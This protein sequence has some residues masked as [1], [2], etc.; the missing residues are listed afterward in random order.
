M[1]SGFGEAGLAEIA[2]APYWLRAGHRPPPPDRAN[3]E[4]MQPI[5]TSTSRMFLQALVPPEGV[6]LKL[7]SELCQ[8]ALGADRSSHQLIRLQAKAEAAIACSEEGR[9]LQRRPTSFCRS[10]G[11]ASATALSGAR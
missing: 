7:L 3:T 8:R 9:E 1:Y 11:E 4:K 6:L 10:P 5:C 2:P